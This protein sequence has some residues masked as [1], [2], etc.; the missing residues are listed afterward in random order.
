MVFE[1]RNILISGP[2]GVGKTTLIRKLAESLK[3]L[4]PQGFYTA[5]IRED[6]IRKGFELVSLDGKRS[7]L[8]HVAIQAKEKVG[9]YRVDVLGFEAFLETIFFFE[10]RSS[11]VIIDEIGKMECLSLKFRRWVEDLLGSERSVLAT[12]ALRG[13]GFIAETKRRRDI[14]LYEVSLG[15][16]DTLFKEIRAEFQ[17]PS[18]F[19]PPWGCEV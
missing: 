11:L 2:P 4:H 15:N 5:E 10:K 13:E 14:R 9:K 7:L 16:R 1:K 6:G 3:E 19:D 17:R 18:N 12:I 8:S